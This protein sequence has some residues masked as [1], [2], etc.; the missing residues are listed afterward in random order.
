MYTLPQVA[1]AYTS[2]LD[3]NSNT[4]DITSI[5]YV[6]KVNRWDCCFMIGLE[7]FPV[8]ILVDLIKKLYYSDLPNEGSIDMQLNSIR[9]HAT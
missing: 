7:P 8:T 3:V 1:H 9:Y 5:N 6:H 4:N 2:R